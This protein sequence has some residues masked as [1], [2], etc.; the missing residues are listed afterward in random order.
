[1]DYLTNEHADT[2]QAEYRLVSLAI[3]TAQKRYAYLSQ[4]FATSHQDRALLDAAIN[5]L[6]TRRLELEILLLTI[7]EHNS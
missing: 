3:G 1:M 4:N 6:K 7:Q 2:L 5:N